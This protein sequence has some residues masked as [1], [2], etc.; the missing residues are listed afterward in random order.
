MSL[1]CFFH[2]HETYVERNSRGILELVC[3]ACGYR[4]EAIKRTAQE[5]RVMAK[6]F[7]VKPKATAQRETADKIVRF[8]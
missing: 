2:G 1:V 6:K 3:L 8:K 7:P 5:R 4:T